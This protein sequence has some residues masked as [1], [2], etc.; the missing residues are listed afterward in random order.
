MP[1][2][3]TIHCPHCGGRCAL[4]PEQLPITCPACGYAFATPPVARIAPAYATP[5]S[6]A[7][8]TI[9]PR[10]TRNGLATTSLVLGILGFI[11]VCGVLAVILGYVG[12]RRART[13][14]FG[15][16][17][18]RTALIGMALGFA[19]STTVV[20]AVVYAIHI[21]MVQ[22]V[23]QA[24]QIQCARNLSQIG[25][26]MILYA[27]DNS[28]PY[29]NSPAQLLTDEDITS[30]VFIC[31]SSNDTP[32]QGA[33]KQAQ[34]ANLL[35]GGHDSYIY[36]GKGYTNNVSANAVM[37]YEPPSNHTGSGSNVL[38]GDGH[39]SFVPAAVVKTMIAQLKA[40]QNPPPATKGYRQPP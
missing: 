11:P 12:F 2:A 18:R 29:P 36:L 31:P 10:P 14:D 34:A 30:M 37:V 25:Q 13:P 28:G 7:R 23:V 22:M 27:N 32:A 6:Y 1:D 15:G 3:N 8:Q 19:L 4:V 38:F 9:N 35:A 33:T 21:A 40:G 5:V 16:I 39:V 24:E 26:A 17:G 20:S